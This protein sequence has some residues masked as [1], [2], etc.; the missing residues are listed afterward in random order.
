MLGWWLS[1]RTPSVCILAI[2]AAAVCVAAQASDYYKW[3]D[4][5]GTVHYSQTAPANEKAQTIYVNDGATTP[6]PPGLDYQP[7]TPQKQAAALDAQARLHK[8]D[9]DTMIANCVAARQNIA[10]LEGGK[11]VV[12]SGDPDTAHALNAEQRQQALGAARQQAAQYCP[13]H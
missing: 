1:M 12:N 3:K 11:M 4:A 13:K 5:N 8:V 6:P 7:Q 10:R 2:L 9:S